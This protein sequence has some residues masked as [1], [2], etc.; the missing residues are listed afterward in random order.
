MMIATTSVTVLPGRRKEFFQ[1]ITPLTERIRAE[2]GCLNY[3]LYEE[4]GDENSM[5]LIEEWETRT[6]WDKHRGGENYAVLFGLLSALSVATK[7][8]FKLLMQVGD[9][10]TIQS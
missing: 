5:M 8:D 6:D 4:A 1:S 2:K 7:I 9:N 10:K 3:R